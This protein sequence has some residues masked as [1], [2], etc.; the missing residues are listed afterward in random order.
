MLDIAIRIAAQAHEGQFDKGGKAYIL[1]P[2]RIMMRLNTTDVELQCIAVLHDVLEDSPVTE[3]DLRQAGISERV[4]SALSLLT[5]LPEHS[6][7]QY[8]ERIATNPDAI[9]VKLGDLSDNSDLSRLKGVTQKDL[10]R[11]AKYSKAYKFLEERLR[12]FE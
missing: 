9:R 1:H 8:V 3:D 11:L 10:D 4:I 2:L 7:Q 6:Y 5:H 12:E